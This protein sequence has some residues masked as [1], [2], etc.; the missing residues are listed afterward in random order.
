MGT[1]HRDPCGHPKLGGSVSQDREAP[2]ALGLPDHVA[3]VPRE[4]LGAAST[5][6]PVSPHSSHHPSYIVCLRTWCR[7]GT[8]L[9]WNISL[10]Q[11]DLK[12]PPCNLPRDGVMERKGDD[13]ISEQNPADPES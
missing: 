8:A 13:G 9:R 2:V 11:G 6:L 10:P 3:G 5:P 1:I 12:A 7:E 4:A